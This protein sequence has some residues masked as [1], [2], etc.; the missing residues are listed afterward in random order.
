[1]GATGLDRAGAHNYMGTSATIQAGAGSAAGSKWKDL[2]EEHIVRA[3]SI[4]ANIP[5]S[6]PRK[7]GAVLSKAK[8]KSV[9]P[10]SHMRHGSSALQDGNTNTVQA[11]GGTSV[12]TKKPKKKAMATLHA[13]SPRESSDNYQHHQFPK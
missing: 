9:V 4:Y 6:Q 2:G 10:S 3:A 7:L 12:H 11:L 13:G 5:L 8:D 1:M